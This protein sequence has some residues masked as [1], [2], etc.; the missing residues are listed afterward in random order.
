MVG[1]F[2]GAEE[3]KADAQPE[4]VRLEK[5]LVPVKKKKKIINKKIQKI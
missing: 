1:L 3:A 4:A 2:W 5:Q